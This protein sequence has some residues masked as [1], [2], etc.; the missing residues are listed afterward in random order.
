MIAP[1]KGVPSPGFLHFK[2]PSG[3]NVFQFAKIRRLQL[4]LVPV[5]IVHFQVVEAEGHGQFFFIGIGVPDAVVQGS[6]GHLAHRNHIPDSGVRHQFLQILVDMRAI[7]VE[8]PSIAAVVIL[9]HSG[10]GNQVYHIEAEPLDAFLL[11]EAEDVFQLLPYLRVIPVQIRLGLVKQM[12][13]PFFQLRHV[14]P[15]VSAEL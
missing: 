1:E 13:I 6:R 7:G 15:G 8:A 9:K 5:F 11:P 10:L 14:G 2:L 3:E 12:Q 4:P